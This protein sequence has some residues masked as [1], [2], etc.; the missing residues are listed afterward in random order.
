MPSVTIG[1]KLECY[2]LRRAASDLVAKV[3]MSRKATIRENAARSAGRIYLG[4]IWKP[5]RIG[6]EGSSARNRGMLLGALGSR[7]LV[8]SGASD[9]ELSRPAS[10][11]GIVVDRLDLIANKLQLH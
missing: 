2:A 3:A 7:R 8:W 5:I 9:V 1:Y 6:Q 10:R 4:E 11:A